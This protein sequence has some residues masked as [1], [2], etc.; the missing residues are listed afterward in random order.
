METKKVLITKE[1]YEFCK[2]ICNHVEGAQPHEQTQLTFIEDVTDVPAPMAVVNGGRTRAKALKGLNKKSIKF[3][4]CI[5]ERQAAYE[6]A[7]GF[8][9]DTAIE[10]GSD[11]YN[12]A[13]FESELVDPVAMLKVLAEREMVNYRHVEGSTKKRAESFYLFIPKN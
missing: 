8:A 6:L 11:W 13:R 5:E 7:N 10:I 1:V 4:E 12:K 3:I 9:K 2:L